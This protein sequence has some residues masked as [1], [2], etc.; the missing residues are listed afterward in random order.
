M[1]IGIGTHV[2]VGKNVIVIRFLRGQGRLYC[3]W[4]GSSYR[5]KLANKNQ[6]KG[7]NIGKIEKF[8]K[9]FIKKLF[10]IFYKEYTDEGDHRL[11]DPTIQLMGA[12][13]DT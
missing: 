12:V 10:L 6:I 1:A 13:T 7:E 3:F 11:P 5:K 2:G 9:N 8:L 4:G